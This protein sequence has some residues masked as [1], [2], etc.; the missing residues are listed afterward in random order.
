MRGRGFLLKSSE[1]TVRVFDDSRVVIKDAAKQVNGLPVANAG[2]NV[3]ETVI[4]SKELMLDYKARKARFEHDVHVKD[5]KME[6]FCDELEVQSGQDNQINW[7]GAYN[8]VR[9]L[10]EG[11]EAQAGK[12][13]YDIK[14]DEFVLEDHPRILDGKNVLM[15]EQIR[16][17]RGSGRMVCE[18]FARLIVY[19]DEKMNTNIFGK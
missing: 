17:W 15:G 3:S 14:T 18:P 5:S 19:S 7:I 10:N 2:T 6:M 16:F 13:T 11:R 9:I 1:N 8:G 12:A 4:T